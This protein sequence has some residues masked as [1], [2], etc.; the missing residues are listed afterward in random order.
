[1][2]NDQGQSEKSHFTC[3]NCLEEST[4]P[5]TCSYCGYPIHEIDFGNA[6]IR[7]PK[8]VTYVIDPSR[9]SIS[10]VR[11]MLDIASER[12][13]QSYEI[14]ESEVVVISSNEIALEKLI[15][16]LG[17]ELGVETD[18]VRGFIVFRA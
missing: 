13:F 12:Y 4:D 17:R 3:F 8:R 14:E 15:E 6:E 11:K 2:D 1:M 18:K 9:F 10:M 16:L 5:V 7:P